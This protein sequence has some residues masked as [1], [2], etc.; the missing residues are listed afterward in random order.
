MQSSVI[1]SLIDETYQVT[2]EK[3]KAKLQS[4]A[5]V[6]SV[7]AILLVIALAYIY[8]Q[9]RR[10]SAAR[11]NLQSANDQLKSINLELKELNARL[12]QANIELSESNQIKEVYIGRFIKL[13]STYIEKLD[14]FRRMVNKRISSGKTD[15]LLQYTRSYESLDDVIQEFYANFDSAFLR[16]FPDFVEKV[17]GLLCPDD[18]IILKKDE[19]LNTELR[20]LALVR[21]GI[22]DSSQIAD[23]LRYSVNTIYNYRAKVKNRALSRDDFEDKITQIR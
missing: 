15:E 1:L 5:I 18:K 4:Y 3:Q 11:H 2:I 20:I 23:F 7:L 16:I 8:R 14:E 17:N 22:H 13:C 12:S 21:L 6:I 19:L 10:L 9:M